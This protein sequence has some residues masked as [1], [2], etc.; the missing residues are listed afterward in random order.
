MMPKLPISLKEVIDLKKMKLYL[1]LFFL[2]HRYGS[3]IISEGILTT[4]MT[5]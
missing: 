1:V 5:G 2:Q 3:V 4:I